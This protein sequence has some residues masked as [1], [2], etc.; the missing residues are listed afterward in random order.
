MLRYAQGDA[1][2]FDTA[3]RTASRRRVPLSAATSHRQP[4]S[5]RGAVPGRLDE[6]DRR[7]RPLSGGGEVHHLALHHGPQPRH[8]PLPP[9]SSARGGLARWRRGRRSARG[10]RAATPHSPSAWRKRASR[11]RACW[12]WSMRCRRPSAR[13]S[14]CTRK[15]GLS[16]EEIAAV[17][18]DRPRSG[19]EPVALCHGQAQAR[20]WESCCEPGT[21]RPAAWR[22]RRLDAG[23]ARGIA[24]RAVGCPRRRHPCG[25]TPG[26]ARPPASDR[27]VA[28]RQSLA[29]AAVGG[30]GAG[31]QC[32][33]HAAGCRA[34]EAQLASIARPGCAARCPEVADPQPRVGRPSVPRHRCGNSRS[35]ARRPRSRALRRASGNRREP[36]RLLWKRARPCHR[37][38]R[39][40]FE[41]RE[42]PGARAAGAGVG[43]A[44]ACARKPL[45]SRLTAAR[46]NVREKQ[47][48][49][50]AEKQRPAAAARATERR[51]ETRS[52]RGVAPRSRESAADLARER[53]DRAAATAAA[54]LRTDEPVARPAAKPSATAEPAAASRAD[55]AAPSSPEACGAR[56]PLRQPRRTPEPKVWLDRIL[57]LRRQGKLEEAD[58]SLKAFRERYPAYPLPPELKSSP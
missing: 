23:V 32:H 15:A 9:P 42:V 35:P 44:D 49:G 53:D 3:V 17:T 6:S 21:W 2:A 33:G 7:A 36:P 10:R 26:G 13:R 27:R 30:S 19:Q 1:A 56:A 4:R 24:R 46:A 47:Q 34:R 31:G 43:G 29:R 52:R 50:A 20:T 18:G 45:P 48:L 16:L 25:G 11:R 8:R 5:R 22:R 12:R 55:R 40:V 38:R 57:E 58:K 51:A 37:L 41:C 28:V 39:T 14:C 54:D